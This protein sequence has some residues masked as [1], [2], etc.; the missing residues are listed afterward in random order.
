MGPKA[1]L[2]VC[3]K[4]RP[5]PGFDPQSDHPAASRYNYRS[6]NC[7]YINTVAN[8]V[9]LRQCHVTAFYA[10]QC[11]VMAVSCYAKQCHVTANS[12]MLSQCHVTAYSV[13]LRQ[14]V[15]CYGSVKLRQTV[16]CYGKQCRV[17]PNSVML[18]QTVSCYAKQC[19]VT[20]NSVMLRQC[21]V[22]ANSVM[23]R[24]NLHDICNTI[25][26]IKTRITY[27]IKV[28]PLRPPRRKNLGAR[29]RHPS[30]PNLSMTCQIFNW[31]IL[32]N[33]ETKK[34]GC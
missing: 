23:L 30:R 4:S 29:L 9:M 19:H 26:K 32:L 13:M 7:T 28:A 2:D 11:H 10:K 16:S 27:S 1:G 3:G 5:P 14:T 15:S 25:F 18:H 6:Y 20:P 33:P 31:G 21:H 34:R 8:S 22:T 17:T 12:V 24:Q